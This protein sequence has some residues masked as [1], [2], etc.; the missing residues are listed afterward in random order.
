MICIIVHIKF[1]K[2]FDLPIMPI[3]LMQKVS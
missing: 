2:H 1:Q 3:D